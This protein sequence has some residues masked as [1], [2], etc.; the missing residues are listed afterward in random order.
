MKTCQLARCSV[1]LSSKHIVRF[2]WRVAIGLYGQPNS[3]QGS[4]AEVEF[5]GDETVAGAVSNPVEPAIFSSTVRARLKIP[6]G[7]T[8]IGLNDLED[9]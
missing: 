6:R 4:F 3:L 7:Y 1:A 5:E 9:Q 8:P 2:Q